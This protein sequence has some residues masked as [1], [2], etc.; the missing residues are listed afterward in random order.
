VAKKKQQPLK[1]KYIVYFWLLV[2]AGPLFIAAHLYTISIGLWGPLPTFEELENPKS[3][4]A[5]EVFSADQKVLGTYFVQNRSIAKYED[6]SPYLVDA[7]VST[8]DERYYWHS[9]VDLYSLARAIILMGKRGGGSTVTQQ[10]A[11]NLFETRQGE[12]GLKGGALVQKPAEWIIATRLERRYTKDEIMALYLNTVDFINGAVGIKS[13][14]KVYFNTSPDSLKIE[15]AAT[16]VGMLKNPALFNPRRRPELTQD[17]R[18]TVFG[19]MVRNGKITEEEKDSLSQIPIELDFQTADHNEGLATYF[20]EYLRN[21]LRDWCATHTKPDGTNY[22]LY[23]DGLRVY[24][25]ID[26]RLQEYAEKAVED[27]I[28]EHQAKFWKDQE[29]NKNAPFR[30]VTDAEIESIMLQSM[31]RSVR[32]NAR[33][34]QRQDIRELYREYYKYKSQRNGYESEIAKLYKDL[35]RAERME[36][37]DEFEAIEKQIKKLKKKSEKLQPDLDR[38]WDDYHVVWKPFDDSL[39]VEF[40]EPV[41]MSI[42]SWDGDIDTVLSP[43]DS[44]RYY[45][46]FLQAGMLS[47]DPR[48]G[49]VRA[50]VGGVNY[51]HFKYDNVKQGSRQV[52][53][54]FKP[55]VYALAMQE[56]WSPC[57]EVLNIPVT[58]EKERWGLPEDWTPKNSDDKFENENISLKKA[59]A[60]SVNTVTA[61]VMKKFGPQAVVDLVREM[62]IT[63]P[64][65]P[66]PA[67]CLGT[68]S[69]SVYEMTAAHCTFTNKGVYTEPVVVTR[70]ED[71]S[72]NV[73]EEFV[74]KTHEVMNEQTAYT[75]I[76]LME[77]VVRYGSGIRLKYRYKLEPPMAGKTGTTQNQSDGW[78]IGHTPDLVTGVWVGCE[79][80]AAHFRT[81]VEGQGA[82]MALP[83]WA[84]YM[85]Q[86]YADNSIEI[87][88]GPFE[89]PENG[90]DVELDCEKYN[91]LKAK[92]SDDRS[93]PFQFD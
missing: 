72:G 12:K 21:E 64:I 57:T 41:E 78:F 79:D 7:L 33:L 88:K 82:S 17:R 46:H 70:I 8:E 75:M 32:Y 76:N 83:I 37:E 58:F 80:R 18:N 60:N 65:D 16:F 71:K 29:R 74:P 5:S 49:F 13:A 59:L 30:G 40:S 52:G 51:R 19:Q 22:D 10:L 39:K 47:M 1:R 89:E 87:S 67:I 31:R 73:L 69:L 43:M 2:L 38:T 85:K 26:S 55:F 23:R 81:I 86:V 28:K 27:H 4:L 35:D 15:Q 3:N 62:G 42:F 9:G 48:T 24:T 53:S 11:K 77:G 50:W 14:S 63:S 56:G 68:P 54:T 93:D 36:E 61:Y 66:Y 6:L 84:L 91:K 90:V 34:D 20:R 44:I 92:I 45:K 25:T